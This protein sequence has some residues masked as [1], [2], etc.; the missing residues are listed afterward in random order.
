MAR[1]ILTFNLPEDDSE[2]LLAKNGGKYYG[3][4]WEISQIMRK[5]WKYDEKMEDCWKEIEEQI[6]EANLDEVS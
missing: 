4:L 2:F 5:H 1:A 3:I 6:N